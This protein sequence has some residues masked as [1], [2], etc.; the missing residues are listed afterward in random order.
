VTPNSFG[1]FN[2]LV[3][4][5]I[6]QGFLLACILVFNKK[7]QK[8]ANYALAA[9]L[10][11]ITL[12][13]LGQIMHN[14]NW[15]LSYP[16]I[17]FLPIR[18]TLFPAIGLYYYIIFQL[19]DT[20][21]FSKKDKWIIAPF[22]LLV[23]IDLVLLVMYLVDSARLLEYLP[24]LHFYHDAKEMIAV[25]FSFIIVIWALKETQQL[26]EQIDSKINENLLKN[27]HWA[28]NNI[29]AT[30]IIW[31]AWAVPQTY[32]ILSGKDFWWMYYPTWIGMFIMIFWLGYFMILQRDF[33]EVPT[34]D[35][36]ETPPKHPALSEKAEEHYQNVLQLM[37]EEKLYRNPALNMNML[38]E[39]ANL[40][41]GYLSQIINQ[42]EGK[43]FY[44]FVNTYRIE[45]VKSHLSDPKYAH[46]SILGIGL[47]AGFK[48][49]STFNA[50]F[51]KMT[52]QTPTAFK[53]S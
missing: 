52:G 11:G 12:L 46:Y 43:N 13:G 42:K 22:V 4:L 50:A 27:L 28:K 30:A 26:P 41:N 21:R 5:G 53:N 2:F 36:K 15:R 23:L 1:I 37:V 9:A 47:E 14:L 45:E 34:E 18:Y 24:L 38:A 29:L 32:V 44:D 39:K 16:I 8:K 17:P 7:F 51:K 40:S 10:F 6:T 48:S 3:L 19:N 33:F 31:S 49:K 25:L 20:Y 35:I